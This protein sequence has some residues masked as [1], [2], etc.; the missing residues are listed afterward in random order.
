MVSLKVCMRHDYR[1]HNF[2][3]SERQICRIDRTLTQYDQRFCCSLPRRR[4]AISKRFTVGF[5]QSF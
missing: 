4:L 2:V 5:Y 1:I 3:V